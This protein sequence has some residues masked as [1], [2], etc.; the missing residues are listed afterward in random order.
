MIFKTSYQKQSAMMTL[1]I[2]IFVVFIMFF[3]GL[4]YLDPPEEYGVAINFGTSDM[5]SGPPALNERIQSNP[6]PSQVSS[7]AEPLEPNI[8]KD[9][10]LT[11]SDVEAPMVSPKE[12]KEQEKTKDLNKEPREKKIENP[13]KQK[14]P[15]PS[16]DTQNILKHLFGNP[17]VGEEVQGEGEDREQGV[18]GSL[19][20]AASS[21]KYYGNEGSG[22]DGNYLLKGRRPLTKPIIKPDC[23]EEGIVVVSIEVDKNGR[24]TSAKAGVKGTT[25]NSLCLLEPARKAALATQWNPDGNAPKRQVGM[26][27]Y[28]FVLS[29]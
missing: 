18:K 8:V 29:E 12:E 7:K 16:E 28:K 23:N 24:V 14:K 19:S 13:V 22:G 4:R 25:N 3:C 5:G 21:A 11:Q 17:S 10:L 6:E 9:N 1:L 27:R 2:M 20:G 15:T 26:I